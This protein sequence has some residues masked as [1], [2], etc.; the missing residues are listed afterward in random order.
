MLKFYI[1]KVPWV[2]LFVIGVQL[3][4]LALILPNVRDLGINYVGMSLA[5]VSAI[6]ILILYNIKKR[7]K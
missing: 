3:H 4:F 7:R 1:D 5:V 6:A 2:I